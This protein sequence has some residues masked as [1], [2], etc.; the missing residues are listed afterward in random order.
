MS[1]SFEDQ[2]DRVQRNIDISAKN[3]YLG[4]RN[5][6]PNDKLQRNNE[7]ELQIETPIKEMAIEEEEWLKKT[8]KLIVSAIGLRKRGLFLFIKKDRGLE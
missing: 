2:D 3:N 6:Q 7:M 8:D 4:Q 5:V 1:D